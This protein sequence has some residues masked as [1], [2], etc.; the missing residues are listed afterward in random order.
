MKN[1]LKKAKIR[2]ARWWW[3]SVVSVL[4]RLKQVGTE[5]KASLGYL[6]TFLKTTQN[7]RSVRLI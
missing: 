5:F 6:L 7:T 4:G 1:A 2:E 3:L